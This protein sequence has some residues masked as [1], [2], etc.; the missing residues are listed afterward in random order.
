MFDNDEVSILMQYL[1]HLSRKPVLTM[2]DLLAL[3]ID[4]LLGV[5]AQIPDEVLPHCV[6]LFKSTLRGEEFFHKISH[7]LDNSTG[8]KAQAFLKRY[9]N[10]MLQSHEQSDSYNPLLAYL[11]PAF[12]DDC[13]FIQSRQPFFLRQTIDTIN[14]FLQTTCGYQG[15]FKSGSQEEA[16]LWFWNYV[17]RK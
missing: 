7:D 12:F 11:P 15:T 17:L 16:W 5:M 13:A 8:P 9:M 3:S 10:L 14:E 4:E 6:S 2:H 1:S